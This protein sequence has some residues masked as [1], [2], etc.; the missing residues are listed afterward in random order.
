[1]IAVI[2]SGIKLEFELVDGDDDD[3]TVVVVDAEAAVRFLDV[4]DL[5][6]S[7]DCERERLPGAS[8]CN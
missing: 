2:L 5:T 6:L 7:P 1:M 4:R 8:S 3:G